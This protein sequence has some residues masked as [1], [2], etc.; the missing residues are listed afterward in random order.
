MIRKLIEEKILIFDGAMGTMVQSFQLSEKDFRGEKFKDHPVDLIGNNDLLVLTQPE[1]VSEIHKLYLNAGADIIETNTF[2]ANSISQSDYKMEDKVYDINYAAAKIA[3]EAAKSFNDKPRFVA[4]AIGPTSRTASLSPDVNDPSYRNTSFDELVDVYSEQIQ[5]LIDGGVDLFLVET[6]FDTLNCKA[7]LFAI[8]QTL[9]EKNLDI[10]IFIS[11]TITDASGR[12]LSGQ[13]VE[14][15]WNSIKHIKPVAVGLNCALGAEQIRPW[16]NDLSNIADTFVFVYPN[17]GLPNELGEYDQSPNDMSAIIEEFAQDGLVNMVGGCCGTTPDHIKA[18]SKAVKNQ[19]PRKIPKVDAYTRLSGLEPFVIRP[20]SNFI[21]V[22]ERTNVTGSARFKKLIKEGDFEAA[23]S[24]ARQQIHNGAQI[25]DINMDEGLLDSEKAMEKFLRLIASEPDIAKVP[26]MID[27]SKWSVI[28]VGLKNLQGK[29]IVNSIS[30]KE[31]EEIFLEQAQKI[32]DYGAAAVIMAFDEEGQADSFDR[33]V[34]ICSR[35]YKLL[36][37]KIDFNPE[38]IIFDPNIFAVATGIDEHNS[39]AKSYIEAAKELKKRFPKVHISG[40]VSNLSFSFRGNE[41]LREAMHSAFLFHAVKSGMDMGIVNA[42]QLTVYDDIDPKLKECIEDVIFD[43]KNDSTDRL[44]LIAQEHKGKKKK[45]K[46]DL[47]WRKTSVEERLSYSLREGIIDY[48]D[49]DI[50]EARKKYDR[51]INVIEGPL[52]DGMNIVGD[53][54]GSGKMFLPQ[55]VKSA[56]VMKKAV[57]Y[58]IPFIDKEKKE[59]G[60]EDV[61]NGRIILATVKGDVH[62]IGKNIVGVVLGCN[63][64]DIVDLGVMVPSDKILSTAKEQGADIIGLS[65]LITPSLD[66]MVH[67]AKEMERLDFD[68]PLL[69]GGA[70]TSKKHT[71]IKIEQNYSGPTIHITDASRSVGAVSKLL[72]NDEKNQFVESVKDDFQQIRDYVSEKNIKKIS[73]D[74]ARKRKHYI[75]WKKYSLLKPNLMGLK[76]FDDYPIGELVNYIDWTPFFHAWE[77]KGKYPSILSHERYGDEAKKIYNDGIVLLDRIVDQKLLNPKAVIGIYDAQAKDEIVTSE[78]LEFDFPRQLVDKGKDKVNYSL[79]DF[80]APNNDYLGL[81]ALTT[82][83]GLDNIIKQFEK[84][85]DDYNII[86]AKVLA[87]RLV[88]AF[89]ERMHERVRKEFWGYAK[90]ENNSNENLIK[91]KF[92]GIRPAPGYPSCPSH[93]E[94]DKIWSILEVEKHTGISLTETR[95]MYPASSICGWYFSHPDSKYFFIRES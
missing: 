11:G 42:G 57:A 12:T 52:M 68:V 73:I 72:N 4:G 22:G 47:S 32:K 6:V 94:K 35:A 61:S 79:A 33:K 53:L 48:I 44:I 31:G 25:I 65:G 55:V 45:I 43:R 66:E 91:E 34:E 15:F 7:A 18:I 3:S 1:I 62:D 54:F 84:D 87:D 36:V 85:N 21:N 40:G 77:L 39:Y 82:G 46:A 80:I 64:Y 29:G 60:L 26:I 59:M 93:K 69:I 86:M 23:L 5:G 24:V 37:E 58:L 70:T 38:D 16:L 27:S 41:I 71:A 2:N 14:A 30:L 74:E 50:E 92:Q 95:A 81:F 13:T 56:R 67:V 28:E 89:A 20:E 51:P 63:G 78:G 19:K 76:V 75:D 90:K 10:P 8:N 17:A 88:E 83:H 49:T 9:I